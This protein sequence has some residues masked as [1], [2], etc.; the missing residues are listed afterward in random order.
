[1]LEWDGATP[2]EKKKYG[3]RS[4]PP[5]PGTPC[6]NTAKM[7]QD[8]LSGDHYSDRAFYALP[9]TSKTG[10]IN[11]IWRP[12]RAANGDFAG[13]ITSDQARHA[14]EEAEKQYE[15]QQR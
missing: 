12:C 15:L 7:G 6:C 4:S 14:C 13:D 10:K 3:N 1:M 5:Y 8:K 9:R 2:S 11:C